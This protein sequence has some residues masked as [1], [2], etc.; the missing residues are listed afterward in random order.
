MKS[1][2]TSVACRYFIDFIHNVWE[3][4][5]VEVKLLCHRDPV[6]DKLL[7]INFR[8]NERRKLDKQSVTLRLRSG[9]NKLKQLKTYRGAHGNGALK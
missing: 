2:A 4:I 8:G 6:N 5:D 9:R 7:G 1:V 3:Y